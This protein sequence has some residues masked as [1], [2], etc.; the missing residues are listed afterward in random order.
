[1]PTSWPIRSAEYAD[2]VGVVDLR[3]QAR[4]VEGATDVVVVAVAAGTDHLEGDLEA[5]V[6]IQRA[7]DRA[8]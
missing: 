5:Q 1:M 4:L 2:D 8:A 7:V 3:E 6:L